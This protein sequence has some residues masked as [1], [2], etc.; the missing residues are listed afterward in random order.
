L[1]TTVL[2][3]AATEFKFWPYLLDLPVNIFE[4]NQPSRDSPSVLSV[5][6]I[7]NKT[8]HA[9]TLLHLNWN[10]KIAIVFRGRTSFH[11]LIHFSTSVTLHKPISAEWYNS[12]LIQPRWIKVQVTQRVGREAGVMWL[13]YV[14]SLVCSYWG[15]SI[16]GSIK[17]L[18]FTSL[19]LLQWSSKRDNGTWSMGVWIS[20]SLMGLCY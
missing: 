20:R 18:S 7:S 16:E 6:S 4:F 5:L 14:V 10:V 8:W 13:V 9:Q 11:L 17:W 12:F 2:H 19:P 3:R 1:V 15:E